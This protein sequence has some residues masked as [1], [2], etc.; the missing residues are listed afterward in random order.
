[1]RNIRGALPNGPSRAFLGH[2]NIN[3]GERDGA[4]SVS[5]MGDD[6]LQIGN[7]RVRWAFFDFDASRV[8]PTANENRPINIGLTP[9]IYLGV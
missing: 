7:R 6:Y 5:G 1:M 9:T 4:I 2:E 8:V 3:V